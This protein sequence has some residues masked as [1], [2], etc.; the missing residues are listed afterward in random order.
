MCYRARVLERAA[1]HQTRFRTPG[2]SP[3]ARGVVLG[4]K[5]A[6]LF[7]SLDRLVAFFQAYSEEGSLDELLAHLSIRRVATPLRTREVLLTLA[8][9]SSYRMDRVSAF[10][11]LTGGLTFTGT[12]RHF[13][14]YRDADSPLGYDV[15]ELL[16][17][18]AD[19]ILYH[20]R[21]EQLY[22]FEREIP[23]RE[24][25]V[26]LSPVRRP[27][28]DRPSLSRLLATA[29]VGVGR[30]LVN[31]L[32][33]WQVEARAGVAEWP[34]RSAF[35]DSAHRL[36]V[37]DLNEPKARIVALL[38]SLPGVHVFERL[39]PHVG[40]ELGFRHPI[41]L[42]SCQ[43]LF[44]EAALTLFRGDGVVQVAEP[45]P[46]FAPVRSLVRHPLDPE[47]APEVAALV[48][49]DRWET[50]DLPLRL[51]T[52]LSP[53]RKVRATVIRGAER[54]WLSRMLYALPPRALASLRI[55]LAAD[56]IYLLDPAGI[57]GVP[58]GR[59]YA[60]VA[61]RVFVPAG[62]TLVP[63]VSESVLSELVADS[64]GGYVFFEP[65]AK[66]PR[67]VPAVS[68]GPVSR[69]VLKDIEFE[70][71]AAEKLTEK[72]VAHPLLEYGRA[73]R[74]PLWGI[75]DEAKSDPTSEP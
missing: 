68:F 35:E 12:A 23:F 53:V 65:G 56:A 3:D 71:V 49:R 25:L 18:K 26:K 67:L 50:L 15:E 4:Q 27:P 52:S 36:F 62:M 70:G 46:P 57:E 5:G 59:F 69:L 32:F 11:K 19:L 17:E 1:L 34:S 66:R 48:G 8:A 54:A 16:D 22:T 39:R 20:D 38:A 47:R 64:D 37:F 41:S 13:V 2:V 7:A 33:R 60:E 31:Y 74:F 58:I 43:S 55:A 44:S 61:D 28:S 72:P 29:E 51:D 40:V 30:A 24:L 6:V 10:A 21:F 14:K 75:P 63:S 45:A 42:E 73:R 9:E